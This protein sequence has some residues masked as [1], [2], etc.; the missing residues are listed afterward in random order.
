MVLQKNWFQTERIAYLGRYSLEVFTFHILLIILFVPLNGPLNRI[1]AIPV[2]GK[3]YFYPFETL[4]AL[5]IVI[6]L[7]AAPPIWDKVSVYYKHVK[8]WLFARS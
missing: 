5:F 3:Y 2:M 7:Y 6:A 4:L 1:M 8:N